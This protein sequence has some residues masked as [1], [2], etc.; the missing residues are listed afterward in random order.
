MK[1][2]HTIVLDLLAGQ[3]TPGPIAERLRQPQSVISAFLEDLELDGLVESAAIGNPSI[4]RKL[5][6]Y[7]LTESGRELAA[8]I[9]VQS[10]P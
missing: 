10:T 3:S 7:R 5:T 6:A 9:Q 4:G 2:S 8:T 1:T